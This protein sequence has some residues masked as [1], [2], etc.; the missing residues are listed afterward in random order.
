MQR[1]GSWRLGL[2]AAITIVSIV[3]L[4][5]TFRYFLYISGDRPT[6]EAQLQAWLEKTDALQRKS[7]PLGLDIRGGV[8]VVLEINMDKAMA[9][10]VETQRRNVLRQFSSER[11]NAALELGD[12]VDGIP[13]LNIAVENE[14]DYRRGA[15]I[16]DK[17]YG[18]LFRNFNA[19]EFEK[20]G[21][22]SLLLSLQQVQMRQKDKID[23]ATKAIR[24]RVNGMG[25][26]QALVSQQGN[27]RI[28][29]QIPGHSDPDEV[30]RTVIRPAFLTFHLVHEDN[31]R[32][33]QDLFENRGIVPEGKL[34]ADLLEG[35]TLPPGFIALP[36]SAPGGYNPMTGETPPDVM[37]IVM[38]KPEVTGE[39]LDIAFVQY[40]PTDIENPIVVSVEFDR[41][42]ARIFREVTRDY[43]RKG[44]QP[45]RQLAIAMDNKV[46]SAPELREE[47]PDGRAVISGKFTNEE[48]RELALV[49]KAGALPVEMKVT[50][51][52]QV[53]A[54][55]G[56]DSI[57][58]SLRALVMGGAVVA[59]FMIVYYGTAGA[60]AVVALILNIMILMAIMRLSHA[61][62]TLSGIGG[63]LLTIGMAV[64]ANVLIYERIREELR[65]GK[66]IKAALS[67]G[68]NRA[69]SVILDSNLTTLL[70][71]MVLLQFGEGSVR[72]F[73]LAMSFGLIANLYTG[74]TVTY[75]LCQAWF[76]WRNKL[77][78]GVLDFLTNPKIDF[79]KL[80]FVAL[81]ISGTLIVASM[82]EFIANRGLNYAVDF[83]G[84]MMV[85]VEM[86]RDI[87]NQEIDQTLAA[88]GLPGSSTQKLADVEGYQ[89]LIRT[90][91][92]GDDTQL[93]QEKIE[94]AFNDKFSSGTIRVRGAQAFTAEIGQEFA[95]VAR[96]VIICASLAI[97]AYLWF[98]FELTFGV[99]AVI[100]LIHDL[101]LTVGVITILKIDISL[102]VVSALMILL[103]Y[104]VN[105]TIVVFDRMRENARESRG[106]NLRDLCNESMNRSL[107]RTLITALTTLFVMGCM[108]LFGGHSLRPFA[109]TLIFGLIFGTY[110]S[111]MLAMPIVYE[112]TIRKRGGQLALAE[113]ATT[114]G[115]R[116]RSGG[117]KT[118]QR[119]KI[120]DN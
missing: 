95:Q 17:Y 94:T 100:A 25:L 77:S 68:F 102:D 46:F 34:R 87:S 38:E 4:T 12:P 27:D 72:G 8:D 6:D 44:N 105:D 13:P 7:I 85:D 11:I 53:E 50:R 83:T 106:K 28:R 62:L 58:A 114:A 118:E 57:A 61:T 39:Y 90:P 5:P 80:R 109:T 89:A 92:F 55:L 91:L 21:K 26:A 108:A 93:T 82:A 14:A 79:I 52:S 81:A 10:E 64:D 76:Q 56:A 120:Y 101:F 18:D 3:I 40:N 31:D 71:A 32:L 43:S 86:T 19:S 70:T 74:L 75:A 51:R 20:T 15:N 107:T 41:E 119:K 48:A 37:Y 99:A 65:A 113:S 104:S 35:K 88:A 33:V 60:I 23:G 1:E 103:G 30:I 110:S 116:R 24:E 84:G 63:I 22:A 69:F 45:G 66:P 2:I 47:I 111:S 96:I 112:W 49:L 9:E 117:E 59:V 73:A 16:L 97:L 78:L 54:T 36:G 67:A 42:G 115:P 29:V 98:R